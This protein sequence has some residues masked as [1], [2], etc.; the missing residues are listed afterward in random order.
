MPFEQ[1][2]KKLG[3]RPRAEKLGCLSDSE[4]SSN[5]AVSEA[6]LS[7]VNSTTS[8]PQLPTP[9]SALPMAIS[10]NVDQPDPSTAAQDS[11]HTATSGNESK[12]T[13]QLLV[14]TDSDHH[15][16][17]SQTIESAVTP[18]DRIGDPENEDLSNGND[19]N[20]DL[21]DDSRIR[22]QPIGS[23]SFAE[24]DTLLIPTPPPIVSGN[25]A[26]PAPLEDLWSRAFESFCEDHKKLSGNEDD[27][28]NR[29]KL[30]IGSKTIVVKEKM[31]QLIPAVL[32]AKDFVAA[33]LTSQPMA[34]LRVEDELYNQ[35]APK[36][37]TVP[38]SRGN[39]QGHL[40]ELLEEQLIQL[41]SSILQ[42]LAQAVCQW[43]RSTLKHYACD[44][45]KADE[46]TKLFTDIKDFDKSCKE[47][48][49]SQRAQA[50]TEAGRTEERECMKIFGACDYRQHKDRNPL[51]VPGTCLSR[52]AVCHFFFKD[53]FV[54]QQGSA[55]C[56]ARLI[57]QILCRQTSL[58]KHAL[59]DFR[60]K[61]PKLAESFLTMWSIFQTM[62]ED[63]ESHEIIS[64]LDALDEYEEFSR[65]Q[66]ID[67]LKKLAVSKVG[68]AGKDNMRLK[69]IVTSR[70]YENIDRRFKSLT[71]ATPTTR[72][73]GEEEFKAIGEEINLV[74]RALV[75]DL[76]IEL[77]LPLSVEKH[78]LDRLLSIPNRTYLRQHLIIDQIRISSG[79]STA[80]RLGRIIDEIPLTVEVAYEDILNKSTDISLAKRLLH[81]II[82]ATRPLSLDEVNVTLNIQQPARTLDDLE[83]ETRN[84]FYGTVRNLCGLFVGI[85][86][87]VVFL[88][89]QLAREYLVQSE[90]QLPQAGELW[91]KCVHMPKAED[92]LAECCLKYLLFEEFRNR[93]PPGLRADDL[94]EIWWD[95]GDKE[96]TIEE[97]RNIYEYLG[98]D[99]YPFLKYAALNW[100]IH[101]KPKPGDELSTMAMALSDPDS[102]QF[103]A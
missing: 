44:V 36:Y 17:Q 58:V 9:T 94:S 57:H 38:P 30:Q 59:R 102:D 78:L 4:A 83:L 70:P 43:S 87:S 66:I 33:A 79:V 10:Q 7:S 14:E 71:R 11:E 99:K 54:D 53:G 97:L 23:A 35:I 24:P 96:F 13:T 92:V 6:P 103:P 42:F 64:L 91:R 61:G 45:F 41:Y 52:P 2:A 8:T 16:E 27:G 47:I 85:V 68:S 95:N 3:L 32:A 39:D 56:I 84:N 49:H 88:I 25:T 90:D 55:N 72:L 100:T 63:P 62:V 26:E 86:D 37:C 5:A 12:S 101:F 28:P 34:G 21:K 74:I 15:S 20:G 69:I 82:A 48:A 73:R 40:R 60:Q 89:H 93:R 1:L 77:D 80:S 76:A 46:W 50:Q 31:D 18:V 19:E 67:S 51:R 75:P 98:L 29:Y 65:F 22:E 81:I